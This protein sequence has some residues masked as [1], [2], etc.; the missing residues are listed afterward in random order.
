MPDRY[1][2][3]DGTLDRLIANAVPWQAVEWVLHIA[4]P[5]LRE[6]IATAVL[7]VV[8]RDPDGALLM[9]TCIETADDD[10]YQIVTARYLDPDEAAI[11]PA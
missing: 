4:R 7:R 2:Y 10:V 1:R 3:A 8:G 5:T 9:V 6:F 11:F